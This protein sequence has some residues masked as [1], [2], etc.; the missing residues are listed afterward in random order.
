MLGKTSIAKNICRQRLHSST[1][2]ALGKTIVCSLILKETQSF[3][4]IS[5]LTT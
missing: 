5:V 4:I 1:M 3:L 2:I